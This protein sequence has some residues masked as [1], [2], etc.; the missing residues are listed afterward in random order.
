MLSIYC[1]AF[2]GTGLDIGV[3]FKALKIW[4]Q[5]R[6]TWPVTCLVIRKFWQVNFQAFH[7]DRNLLKVLGQL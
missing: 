2:E 6:E 7:N 3:Q 4:G 1:R 5:R